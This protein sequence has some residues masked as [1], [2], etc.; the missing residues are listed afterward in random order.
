MQQSK[1]IFNVFN[2]LTLKQ[3]FWKSKTICKKLEKYFLVKRAKIEKVIFWYKT[4]PSVCNKCNEECK[5]DLSQRIEFCLVT[6]FFFFRKFC[7][8][9]RTSYNK[10]WFNVPTAQMSIFILFISSEV[11]SELVFFPVFFLKT[12]LN[13]ETNL[14]CY[15]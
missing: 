10:S 8:S 11:L 4:A 14:C 15:H 3:I 12:L 2:T 5:M 9:L 13:R 1:K 6:T 7:L